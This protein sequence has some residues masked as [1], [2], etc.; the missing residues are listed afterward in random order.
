MKP[1]LLVTTLLML[2]ILSI[3][4]WY[5]L[6]SLRESATPPEPAKTPGLDVVPARLYGVIEP[7]G[8]EVFVGPLQSSRDGDAN[9]IS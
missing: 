8:R 7:R 2:A 9:W 6:Q 5:T 4:T 3:G 1:R